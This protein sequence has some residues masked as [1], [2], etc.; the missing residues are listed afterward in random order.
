[1]ARAALPAVIESDPDAPESHTTQTQQP[2]DDGASSR[3]SADHMIQSTKKPQA[4]FATAFLIGSSLH[5]LAG[6]G[7]TVIEKK[8]DATP[9]C[10]LDGKLCFDFQERFHWEIRDDNFDFND[11]LDSLTDDN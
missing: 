3:A 6:D 4:L 1:M 10:F 5:T 7:K 2:R 9:L 8:P 11:A